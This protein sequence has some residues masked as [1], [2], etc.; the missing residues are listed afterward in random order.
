[1]FM[2]PSESLIYDQPFC[3][4]DF[5]WWS[6]NSE[7]FYVGLPQLEIASLPGTLWSLLWIVG[8]RYNL[9]KLVAFLKSQ[10]KYFICFSVKKSLY[11]LYYIKY[12][13]FIIYIYIY[14]SI[15]YIIYIAFHSSEVDQ[16]STRNFWGLIGKIIYIIHAQVFGIAVCN[17][18]ILN[19]IT[20]EYGSIYFRPFAKTGI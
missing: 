14:I 11:V 19:Y 13:Y 5:K 7:D 12:M 20:S 4:I 15:Y 2:K 17:T 6:R 8:K 16:M 9:L 3:M 18:Q 10:L 1:M